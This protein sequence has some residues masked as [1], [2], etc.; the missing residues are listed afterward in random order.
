[1]LDFGTDLKL[2]SAIPQWQLPKNIK[3]NNWHPVATPEL[4][5]AFLSAEALY[6]I[7][8]HFHFTAK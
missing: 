5:A 7:V 2:I 1:M 6:Q 3:Y 8:W 4:L